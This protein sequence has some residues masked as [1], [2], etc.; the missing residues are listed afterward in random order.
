MTNIFDLFFKQNIDNLP[1]SLIRNFALLLKKLSGEGTPAEI[2]KILGWII[3]SRL[4]EIGLPI[5]KENK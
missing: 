4:L 3:N 5:T 1:N 2:K